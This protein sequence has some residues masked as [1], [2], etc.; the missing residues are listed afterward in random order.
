MKKVLFFWGGILSILLPIRLYNL[1]ATVRSTIYTGR[2]SRGFKRFGKSTISSPFKKLLGQQYISVGDGVVIHDSIVLTAWDRYL[3]QRFQPEIIIA[4]GCSLGGELHI[5]AINKIEIGKNVLF[6][7][8]V[9]L[10]DNSHGLATAE[11]IGLRPTHRHLVSKGPIII[12]S[13]VWIG[14]KVTVLAGVRIGENAI[15]GANSVVTKDVE[16]NSVYGG[17]PARLLKRIKT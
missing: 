7:R 5:S 11:D 10:V 1:F 2:V 12:E 17:S 3:D 16:P 4:D 15:I 9:T 6:G 14:D 8:K 13:N